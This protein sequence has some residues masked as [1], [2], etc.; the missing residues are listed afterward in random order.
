MD[1]VTLLKAEREKIA[2]ELSG[3][4]TAIQALSGSDTKQRRTRGRW[5]MSAAAKAKISAS[6]KEW[7]AKRQGGGKVVS[8]IRKPRIST[9]GLARIRAATKARWGGGRQQRKKA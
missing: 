3:L 5:H 1:I 9:A 2:W 4:N 8:I 7:W 6:K